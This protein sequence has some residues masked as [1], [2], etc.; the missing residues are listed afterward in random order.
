[1]FALSRC[2]PSPVADVLLPPRRCPSG[3]AI[4]IDSG[5]YR[6]NLVFAVLGIDSLQWVYRFGRTHH[7]PKSGT[8]HL[9]YV[10]M[11]V[12]SNLSKEGPGFAC[13]G[14]GPWDNGMLLYFRFRLFNLADSSR[15]CWWQC[16]APSPCRLRIGPI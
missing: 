4:V 10:I 9:A 14:V 5:F 15:Y 16:K 12:V 6:P 2:F 1:M 11:G 13:G 7:L 8:T 3:S